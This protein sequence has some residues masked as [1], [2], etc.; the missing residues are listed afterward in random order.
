M[1]PGA[2]NSRVYDPTPQAFILARTQREGFLR[3]FGFRECPF[4]VT[5]DPEFLFWSQRHT[6]ALEALINSI[7]SNLGFSVL[8]GQPG[9]GKTTLLFHLLAQYRESARTAF[10]FQTQ[11][12][13]HDLIRHIASELDLPLA[14]DDEV[15]LHRKLNG[16]LLEEARA[17]RKVV[18]VIDEAQNLHAPSLEAIRLLSD[19]ETGPSK[20][21]QVVLSGSPQLGE[22]LLNRNL[23]Q[24]AQRIT[25]ICRLEPLSEDEVQQYVTSRLAVV[26]S[27][28]AMGFFSPESLAEIASQSGGAPRI[29]NSICYGSLVLA[30]AY[31]RSSV[32]KEL[33]RQA[34]KELDFSEPRN[35]ELRAAT[36]RPETVVPRSSRT[37]LAILGEK[38]A[39]TNEDRAGELRRKT[40]QTFADT[41]GGN[42]PK[43][44]AQPAH[45]SSHAN[46]PDT[47]LK[48]HPILAKADR[49]GWIRVPTP[50]RKAAVWDG[51][52]TGLLAV[53]VVLA[54]GS[55]LGWNELRGTPT[56]RGG[57][58]PKVNDEVAQTLIQQPNPFDAQPTTKT[59]TLQASG[60]QPP[61][62]SVTEQLSGTETPSV[63]HEHADVPVDAR[64]NLVSPSKIAR[65]ET[66]TE[67][68]APVANVLRVP[69]N[70]EDLSPL[71]AASRPAL[72]RLETPEVVGPPSSPHPIKIVRPDYP[73]KAKLSHIQGE[74]QVE[75]TIDR[76]GKVQKVR[77]LSGNPILL[78]AA[79]EAASQWRYSPSAGDQRPDLAVTRVQFNFNLNPE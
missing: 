16:M 55:W 22:M 60:I 57:Q 41:V 14:S 37:R 70:S 62:H 40:L 49:G 24:L 51:R 73:T 76:N 68:L 9:T 20:L 66:A 35:R 12:R 10:I 77:G 32:T 18:I 7:E 4:G 39:P 46:S 27:R 79:E 44:V 42:N 17:G 58:S 53:L 11:C 56:A 36:K 38:D 5:P 72:P 23:W 47:A 26:T 6:A 69:K 30:Y 28:A 67:P 78:Q 2:A 19:F 54:F 1:H 15:F 74:V 63:F 21:L 71:V 8:L 29:I 3:H 65:S 75:L 52:I 34:A 31:G 33:V 45:E 64:P 48:D 43:I 25:T 50:A 13:P 59:S 61:Q